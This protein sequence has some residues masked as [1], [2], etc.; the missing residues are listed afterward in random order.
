MNAVLKSLD[1]PCPA[2]PSLRRVLLVEDN[3]FIVE[4]LR[5]MLSSQF[6]VLVARDA[7]AGLALARRER[8]D[9][10]ITDLYFG[11]GMSGQA[12]LQAIRADALLARTPVLVISARAGPADVEAS[13]ALGANGHMGKPFSPLHLLRWLEALWA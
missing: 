1:M 9:V 12:L 5:M 8:P 2:T 10:V 6:E 3:A 4:L 13:L 11:P 7:A